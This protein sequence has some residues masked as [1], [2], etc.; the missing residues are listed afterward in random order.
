MFKSLLNRSRV[1]FV[2]AVIFTAVLVVSQFVPVVLADEWNK[3]TILTF[4]QPV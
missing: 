3:K 4:K 1:H 2:A